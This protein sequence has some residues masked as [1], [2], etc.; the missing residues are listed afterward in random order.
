[1]TLST[2]LLVQVMQ[3]ILKI[4]LSHWRPTDKIIW[5]QTCKGVFT[6]KS[7]YFLVVNRFSKLRRNLPSPSTPTL[8][9]KKLWNCKM[10]PTI[11][12]FL[13]R[14]CLEVLS[15][16]LALHRRG[17]LVAP[18]CNLYGL[19]AESTTHALLRCPIAIHM[20]GLSSLNIDSFSLS[21]FSMLQ[22][23]SELLDNL[24]NFGFLIFAITSW[25]LWKFRIS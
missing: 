1:M 24:P 12:H 13:W 21:S 18:F 2:T 11:C 7:D 17:M 10:P 8:T 9:W 19:E 23:M 20:W 3:L 4:P 6:V 5:N 15:T 25:N 16:S 22:M 14:A